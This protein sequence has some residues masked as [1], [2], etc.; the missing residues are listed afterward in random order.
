MNDESKIIERIPLP[1]GLQVEFIDF[2]RK[3]AGDRWLVGFKARIPIKV[4]END[5]EPFEN[6]AHVMERFFSEKGDTVFFE[7]KRER[8]FI[9]E[10]KKDEVLSDLLSK[11]KSHMLEY[12][13]HSDF[14]YGV[15]RDKLKDFEERLHWYPDEN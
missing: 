11:L 10:K 1:N 13:G 6:S 7:I 8:N 3:V 9:D 2:S 14:A 15:K 4:V 12:M 5:F